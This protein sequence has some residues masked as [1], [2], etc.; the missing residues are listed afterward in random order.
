MRI[1]MRTLYDEYEDRIGE[2]EILRHMGLAYDIWAP[3]A[4]SGKDAGKVAGDNRTKWLKKL[5]DI[6]PAAH[7]KVAY[8]RWEESFAPA[9]QLGDFELQS[10]LLVGHGNAAPT[11]VGLTVHHTWGVPVIPGSALK[12]LTANYVETVLGPDDVELP[13]W[14]QSDNEQKERARFQGV[15]WDGA[16]IKSGPGDVYRALFGAPDAADDD[17]YKEN[18][19]DAGAA[20][21][22]VIFHDALY[23]PASAGNKPFAVDVLTPHQKQY[24]DGA[25]NTNTQPWP[26]DYD[27]PVPIGF[28]SVRPEAKFL[29]ALSGP[30]DYLELVKPLLTA[31]LA[32]WGIGGKTAAGY[33]RGQV[34]N[35]RSPKAAESETFQSFKAWFDRERERLRVEGA[36]QLT[37]RQLLDLVKE[38]WSA[39]LR[40]LAS[41]DRTRAKN[42]ISG[43]IR[44]RAV[45]DDRDAFFQDLWSD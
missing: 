5:E 2:A 33:G 4:T 3:V 38:D 16:R 26:C 42:L 35:W 19:F 10:R 28:L 39:Q 21:G 7:Y 32:D 15:N 31:A 9:D 22:D 37:Q 41:D 18:R 40:S 20:R 29:I 14:R 44:S 1:V 8:E 34:A 30:P 36:E 17:R 13:P 11:E 6:T 23:I 27:D 45:R 25:Q 12:G 43:S 24:Y